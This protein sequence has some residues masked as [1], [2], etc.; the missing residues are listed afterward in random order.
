MIGAIVPQSRTHHFGNVHL[1]WKFSDRRIVNE[2]SAREIDNKT[3]AASRSHLTGKLIGCHFVLTPF[4]LDHLQSPPEP[5]IENAKPELPDPR[6]TRRDAS[7]DAEPDSP[8]TAYWL[9]TRLAGTTID[10]FNVTR[11]ERV[12]PFIPPRFPIPTNRCLWPSVSS[13][14][15]LIASI[16][17]VRLCKNPLV[18][19][20]VLHAGNPRPNCWT[21]LAIVVK[22]KFPSPF[23]SR[24]NVIAF[25]S[26]GAKS[27]HTFLRNAARS[28]HS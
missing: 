11:E 20:V 14:G 3:P 17:S 16:D 19:R 22:N 8:R 10:R 7:F 15:P 28:R 13:P 9:R 12:T 2:C 26:E 23:T 1:R 6:P 25:R 4:S 24:F 5:V 18:D 27:S 21:R